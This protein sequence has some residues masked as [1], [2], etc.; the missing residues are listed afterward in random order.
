MEKPRVIAVDS[1][2]DRDIH[3][4]MY[5]NPVDRTYNPLKILVIGHGQHGKDEFA[6]RLAERIGMKFQSS[7]MFACE[8]V[9][10]P[11]FENFIPG[12]YDNDSVCYYDRRN[13]R[14]LWYYLI[15]EY[16][17]EDKTRLAR[18][19]MAEN[20]AYVGMR[21]ADE[22]EA[23]INDQLFTHIFWVDAGD[24]VEREHKTSI[25]VE[26]NPDTMFLVDNS[27]DLELLQ[28]EIELIA[29]MLGF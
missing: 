13:W 10:F 19:I 9:V 27:G 29:E 2:S 14:S 8:R 17:K 3:S 24:R 11:W 21:A 16:N 4:V 23:C 22:L 20:D 26:F 7:S 28:E 12:Y 6:K 5:F 25:S 15:C 1:A 18:E